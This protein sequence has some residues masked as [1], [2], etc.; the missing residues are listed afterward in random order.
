MIT[1]EQV[2]KALGAVMD[3]ELHRSIVDLGMVRDIQVQGNQVRFTLA[4]T[5]LACPLKGQIVDEVKAAIQALAPRG[6]L[7][8]QVDVVEMTSEERQ[9]IFG[10]PQPDESL[11]ARFNDIHHVIAVMSGKGGVGKSSV[12]GLLAVALKRQGHT[13]GVLDADITGPSVPRM[14]GVNHSPLHGPAGIIPPVSKTGI[15][16]MSINLLLPDEDEAVVWRGPLIGGVIKQFW[17]DVTWGQLDTL[18]IDLPPGTSDASLTVMQSIP[19]SGVVLV[20]SPQDLAGMVVRKAAHM[21]EHLHVPILGLVENMAYLDCPGCDRRI[22]LFGPSNAE[23]N[24]AR[25]G[26]PFLG[27]LPLDPELAVWCDEGRIEDYRGTDFAPVA[28]AIMERVPVHK[29]VP[30]MP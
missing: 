11:A 3:P 25:L 9:R 4:L 6:D 12:A 5:T 26:I 23:A 1:T 28:K 19:L 22:Q 7:D 21:A 10:Q 18:V 20:T 29:T 17:G 15:A 2:R 8:V 30:S 24:A 14:F 27:S 16:I 13:V